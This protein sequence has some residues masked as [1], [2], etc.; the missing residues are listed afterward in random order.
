MVILNQILCWCKWAEFHQSQWGF[1]H[2]HQHRIQPVVYVQNL[3]LATEF[4]R[5]RQ[6]LASS[7]TG[8]VCVVLQPE[9]RLLRRIPALCLCVLL[10]FWEPNL[11]HKARRQA[12]KIYDLPAECFLFSISDTVFRAVIYGWT[13]W[14]IHWTMCASI[15]CFYISVQHTWILRELRLWVLKTCNW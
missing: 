12:Q 15:W 7:L 9:H 10:Q 8:W 2:F 1:P 14:V 11:G 4:Q 6:H 5:T 13:R 3:A